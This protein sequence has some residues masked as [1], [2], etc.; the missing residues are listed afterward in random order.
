MAASGWSGI[1]SVSS[2]FAQP[3]ASANT[4]RMSNV[5]QPASRN[6]RISSPE[7]CEGDTFARGVAQRRLRG[8]GSD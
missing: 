7:T 4:K 5:P 3:D 8:F 2:S 1:G 6:G